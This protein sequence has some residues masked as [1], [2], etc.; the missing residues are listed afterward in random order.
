MRASLKVLLAY[1]RRKEEEYTAKVEMPG[2][3]RY[4]SYCE[5]MNIALGMTTR[6][7]AAAIKTQYDV[8]TDDSIADNYAFKDNGTTVTVQCDERK[9][10]LEKEGWTSN[11]EFDKP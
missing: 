7:V 5:Q 10:T 3:L 4:V 11:C 6:W 1:Q 9:H 8:A 2:T